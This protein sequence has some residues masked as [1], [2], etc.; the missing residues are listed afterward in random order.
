L[1]IET[2][3]K[4]EPNLVIIGAQKSGTT[5]LYH[6]LNSHPQIFMSSPIKEPGYFMK[7]G[8]ILG[9]FRRI[10]HPVASRQE[11][12]ERYMLKGYKPARYFGDASAFYTLGTFSRDHHVPARMK[13]VDPKMKLIYILRSPFARIVS[14]YLHA[15][16]AGYVQCDFTQYIGTVQYE[17]ALLTS[18]YWHQLQVY[19]RYFPKEQIKVVL[20]EDLIEDCQN[21]VDDI[22]QFLELESAG[23]VHLETYNRSE[24]RDAFGT[25]DLLFPSAAFQEAKRAI[26]PE[27]RKLE[28]FMHR[29]L[30]SW[31]LDA[32]Q[33][34]GGPPQH[35][36]LARGP[37]P[38]SVA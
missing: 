28:E 25:G 4:R 1:T 19:L 12:L 21:S 20:F 17:Q 5:S 13:K 26:E 8:F 36:L 29:S 23:E 6:C 22:L 34:C 14:S 33:W 9:L 3:L 2:H 16:R 32:E 15:R 7:L 18:R 11:A 31:D 37:S 10:N 35:Q 38:E 27:V 24:N 30:D